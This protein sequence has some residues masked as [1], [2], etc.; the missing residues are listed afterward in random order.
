MQRYTFDTFQT[1]SLFQEFTVKLT[2]STGDAMIH[3]PYV[4]FLSL[5]RW[6]CELLRDKNFSPHQC[7][8]CID[9][10]ERSSVFDSRRKT[11]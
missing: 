10:N 2:F 6:Y 9:I 4:L 3:A 11:E 7:R 8:K 5:N 1:R